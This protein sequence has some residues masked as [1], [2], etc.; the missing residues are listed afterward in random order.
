MSNPWLQVPASDYEAHMALPEVGQAQVLNRLFALT[1]A[2]YAPR[3]LVVLGCATGNGFEHIDP[4]RTER[5]AAV[6]INPEYL[7]ILRTRFGARIP[8][9]NVIQADFTDPK[10]QIAPVSMV[11]AGLVFEYVTV[12]DALRNITR[13]MAPEATLVAVLQ[14][15]SAK[16][17]PVTES[18]Y[19]SLELL[20]PAMR[21]VSPEEFTAACRMCPSSRAGNGYNPPEE[22]KG[23]LCW[24]ISKG[25]LSNHDLDKE[26]IVNLRSVG[27]ETVEHA[28]RMVECFE[29]LAEVLFDGPGAS[30]QGVDERFAGD[31]RE[32][33]AEQGIGFVLAELGADVF[34]DAWD[35]LVGHPANDVGRD[36]AGTD[37]GASC[38]EYGVGL[39]P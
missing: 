33:P 27:V 24:P 37:A 19:K 36:V 4:A 28:E 2:E 14:L 15:P 32:G 22:G 12:I 3:S 10:L 26:E 39:S 29:D 11:F 31:S 35:G 23:V 30:G 25:L 1:L 9:L 38:G 7:A 18:P 20:T 21:L 6:D 13:F 8:C 16:S 17:A 5:V 34:H